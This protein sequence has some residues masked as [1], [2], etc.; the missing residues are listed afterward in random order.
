G[1]VEN[2]DASAAA[3]A[4]VREISR[5]AI[6]GDDACSGQPPHVQVN[7]AARAAAASSA[8]GEAAVGADPPVIR[9]RARDGQA[10]RAS[11]GAAQAVGITAI[12]V[13]T[14]A[15]EIS[16]GGNRSVGI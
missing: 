7:A 14:S 9:Q 8:E 10:Q 5:A 6:C 16:R 2:G 11:A 4:A 3:A 1:A 13:P 15:A 12:A